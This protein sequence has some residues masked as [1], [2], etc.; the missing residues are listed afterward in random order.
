[1]KALPIVELLREGPPTR[2]AERVAVRESTKVTY[3]SETMVTPH[4]DYASYTLS[5]E[6]ATQF[7]IRA[8]G[9]FGGAVLNGHEAAARNLLGE[10]FAEL[11][12][13]TFAIG[14]LL[15]ELPIYGEEK[16]EIRERLNGIREATGFRF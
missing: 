6:I 14:R 5:A 16:D 3:S 11:W 15:D 7:H 13:E 4:A 10:L 2:N 9:D 1:M 12:G 8:Q